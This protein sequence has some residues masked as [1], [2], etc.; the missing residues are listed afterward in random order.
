MTDT[1]A[2]DQL[3]LLGASVMAQEASAFHD[4]LQYDSKTLSLR[5]CSHSEVRANGKITTGPLRYLYA[6]ERFKLNLVENKVHG[7]FVDGSDWFAKGL[8]WYEP[9]THLTEN[10]SSLSEAGFF[11]PV[12]KT[13]LMVFDLCRHEDLPQSRTG[14]SQWRQDKCSQQANDISAMVECVSKTRW[15]Y[16]FLRIRGYFSHSSY[17]TLSKGLGRYFTQMVASP[18]TSRPEVFVL[19]S[20]S[21]PFSKIDLDFAMH[22][23]FSDFV[24]MKTKNHFYEPVSLTELKGMLFRYGIPSDVRPGRKINFRW[25]PAA[26]ECH[27]KELE[28]AT[29]AGSAEAFASHAL[30]AK[31][32]VH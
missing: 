30:R 4:L 7:Y 5:M 13:N 24:Q 11:H 26:L 20:K 23:Y 29:E 28:E 9:S 27:S 12:G 22:K 19:F 1:S 3:K 6:L 8:K 15:D 10:D 18:C 2:A 25:E 14:L 31:R 17:T 32:Y 16:V 21:Q